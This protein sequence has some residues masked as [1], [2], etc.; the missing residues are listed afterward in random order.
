MPVTYDK[1]INGETLTHAD[2]MKRLVETI[3]D[4]PDDV[5]T[6][7]G[8]VEAWDDPEWG[9]QVRRTLL[10]KY[11]K[12]LYDR[13]LLERVAHGRYKVRN[14]YKVRGL[15]ANH[16][17]ERTVVAFLKAN[18]GIARWRDVKKHFGVTEKEGAGALR[19]QIAA[20]TKVRRDFSLS[21]ESLG[22]GG[23]DHKEGRA[24][25]IAGGGK[26]RRQE[27]VIHQRG[28]RLRRHDGYLNLPI[29]DL[30]NLILQ[31]RWVGLYQKL[32][33]FAQPATTAGTMN[34]NTVPWD[35]M[36][37]RFLRRV[38]EAFTELRDLN[39]FGCYDVIE[40]PRV[41]L[42]IDA[43]IERLR[44]GDRDAFK[45]QWPDAAER[46]AMFLRHFEGG[47][48]DR[49]DPEGEPIRDTFGEIEQEDAFRRAHHMAVRNDFYH[50]V[51]SVFNVASAPLSRGL[52]MPAFEEEVWDDALPVEDDD[53]YTTALIDGT[54]PYDGGGED[55]PIMEDD[56]LFPSAEA[57]LS[58]DF[59]DGLEP[60]V[61]PGLMTFTQE[62]VGDLSA[63][64]RRLDEEDPLLPR[65]GPI[66]KHVIKWFLDW[67]RAQRLIW[68]DTATIDYQLEQVFKRGDIQ[69]NLK[70]LVEN[71]WL[72]VGAD[73]YRIRMGMDWGE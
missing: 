37:D 65:I 51:A 56:P 45:A 68:I 40:N 21:N 52:L 49:Y 32:A 63:I 62:M 35:G 2:F 6:V 10:T 54:D 9:T 41:A 17:I 61:D 24:P 64:K 23:D 60:G 34:D 70:P 28:A 55:A 38:G 69:T 44:I 58:P 66:Q 27:L 71:G 12:A 19:V 4:L 13:K 31:G 57:F 33:L 67:H 50:A 29:E 47:V 26:G 11:L 36:T 8:V 53:A 18:G 72:Q 42:A 30:H 3:A 16:Q 73:A 43:A 20:S 39:G 59:M 48:H 5:Q 46:R 14:S 15:G 1:T 7:A 25:S 22:L